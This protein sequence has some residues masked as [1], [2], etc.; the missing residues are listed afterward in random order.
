MLSD[1]KMLI[2]PDHAYYDRLRSFCFLHC[3]GLAVELLRTR[4]VCSLHDGAVFSRRELFVQLSTIEVPRSCA[5]MDD[6]RVCQTCV[7]VWVHQALRAASDLAVT[8][9][10]PIIVSIKGR[11][12]TV[13][14]Y[15][16]CICCLGSVVLQ[17]YEVACETLR[18]PSQSSS[19]IV[20]MDGE[21]EAATANAYMNICAEAFSHM[22]TLSS[23]V[24]V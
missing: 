11:P 10:L 13:K 5:T 19:S 9:Q 23:K 1:A 15:S 16:A 4:I 17:L 2:G 6:K 21:N 24:F 7:E 12:M 22:N 20:Q 18:L 3:I 14:L 8:R